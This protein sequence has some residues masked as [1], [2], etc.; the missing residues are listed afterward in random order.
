METVKPCSRTVV[1]ATEMKTNA[2]LMVPSHSHKRL[3][4]DWEG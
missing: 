4:I 3:R 2:V 1:S